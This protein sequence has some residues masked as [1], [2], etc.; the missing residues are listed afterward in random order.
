MES[1][2]VLAENLCKRI[3]S[4]QSHVDLLIKR[5]ERYNILI[6]MATFKWI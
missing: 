6:L 5:R 2:Y 3:G 1:V 4:A